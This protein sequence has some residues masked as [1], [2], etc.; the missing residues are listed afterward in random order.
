M[1][2]AARP[3]V[4]PRDAYTILLKAFGFQGWWPVTVPGAC[5]PSY[6]PR[7]Y[8]RDDRERF[9]I[10][11][12]AILTQ[13]TAWTNVEKALANLHRAGALD[14]RTL[15]RMPA[16]ALARLIR[17]S[18]YYNQK[19]QRLKSLAAFFA[20][21]CGNDFSAYF[22][23][24]L[25]SIRAELLAQHG[26]GPETADS[27][28]LYAGNKTT[29]V[30]DTY[31]KRLGRRLGWFATDDYERVKA[32]FEDALPLT[33]RVCNE[34]HALIVRLAKDHCRAKPRCPGCPLERR[35]PTAAKEQ[36]TVYGHN[37]QPQ[38]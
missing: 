22:A 36:K 26:V 38:R 35:C 9:E 17:P 5:M 27:I 21:A 16:A 15:A 6:R 3:G 4:T 20:G 28:L 13:N 30:V 24:P 19:A 18:G 8:R 32:Y 31:T 10:C 29:F 1:R 2:R 14:R 37:E 25:P 11:V 23:R 7:R 33:E 12:G 34:F